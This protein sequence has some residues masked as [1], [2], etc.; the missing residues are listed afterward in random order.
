M[1]LDVTLLP[2]LQDNYAYIIKSANKIAIIDPGEAKPILKYLQKNNIKPDYII[3]THHHLDH[4]DGNKEIAAQY[5]LKIIAPKK[6]KDKIGNVDIILSNGDIFEFGNTYFKAIETPG[7]TQGH[8]CLSFE[9]DRILFSGDMIFAM[10]CGRPME[11][12][13]LDL[14]NSFK[15]FE[16]LEDDTLVYCG[17]EYTQTNG[18]F[19]LSIAPDDIGISSRMKNINA[20]RNDNKPTIPTTL[21]LERATNLFMRTK[22]PEEFKTLRDQR[23]NF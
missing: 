6:D 3:N 20:L 18:N 16:N 15:K 1:M 23:N 8:L 17:H 10:G 9:E 22:N 13:V 5:D 7:H 14:F 11:G 4:T 2:I 19:S 12:S 21:G